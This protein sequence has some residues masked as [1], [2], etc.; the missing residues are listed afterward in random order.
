[1]VTKPSSFPFDAIFTG[2]S[3][4]TEL[5]NQHSS[6]AISPKHQYTNTNGFFTTMILSRCVHYKHNN[7]Y[8]AHWY[9]TGFASRQLLHLLSKQQNWICPKTGQYKVCI[10][11]NTKIEASYKTGQYKTC[12]VS[13]TKSEA[14][15]IAPVAVKWFWGVI[16]AESAVIWARQNTALCDH[17]YFSWN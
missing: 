5:C 16:L 14:P 4:S 7:M 8:C 11:S 2:F 13:N 10:V 17:V 15:L 12:I 1:M 9:K 3:L 6:H